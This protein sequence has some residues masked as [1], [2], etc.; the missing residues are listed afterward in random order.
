[1]KQIVKHLIA[2]SIFK[3]F[4]KRKLHC[5]LNTRGNVRMT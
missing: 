4:N 3:N 5:W 2:V 1:V